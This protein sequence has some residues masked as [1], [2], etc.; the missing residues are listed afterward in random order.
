MDVEIEMDVGIVCGTN[1]LISI[2]ADGHT[3]LIDA[4]E[5]DQLIRRLM[6]CRQTLG[7]DDA[8][9]GRRP[10]PADSIALRALAERITAGDLD[11][12]SV[13]EQSIPQGKFSTLFL[14]RPGQRAVE[15]NLMLARQEAA[16]EIV[17]GAFVGKGLEA[18]VSFNG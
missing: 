2:C 9:R 12:R 16:E 5:L 14:A 8:G 4:C 18:G 11:I 13:Y 17:D 1:D 7:L 15:A 3:V 6:E 10:E